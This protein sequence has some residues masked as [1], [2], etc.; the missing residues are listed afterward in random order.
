MGPAAEPDGVRGT[1]TSEVVHMQR[2]SSGSHHADQGEGGP[3][4]GFL[5]Q[6][7]NFAKRFA[8]ARLT[9]PEATPVSEIAPGQARVI[10][11]DGAQVAAYRDETGTLHAVSA[12]CTHMGCVVDFNRTERTWDCPCHGSRYDY[13]GQV[14]RGPAKRNLEVKQVEPAAAARS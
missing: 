4:E 12:V 1:I 2:Q 8:R 11:V 5:A 10:S 6:G 13:D 9:K 14:I 3:P 7:V